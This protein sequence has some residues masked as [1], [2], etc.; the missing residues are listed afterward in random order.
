M[1][2]C[3]RGV[4]YNYTPPELEVSERE[5]AGSYR[6]RSLRFSYVRH[7][8]FPQPEADMTFR[9]ASYRTN[10]HGRVESAEQSPPAARQSKFA[11]V[12]DSMAA[13]RRRLLQESASIHRESIRRSLERRLEIAQTRGDETLVRQLEDEMHQIA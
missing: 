8:P 12:F 13:A 10:R 5:A 3:Y 9:G 6:G 4:Q 2:L 1:K 11:P 7:V